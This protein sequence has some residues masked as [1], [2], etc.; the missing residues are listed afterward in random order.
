M[1]FSSSVDSLINSLEKLSKLRESG[2]ITEAEFLEA[3]ASLLEGESRHRENLRDLNLSEGSVGSEDLSVIIPVVV[4][5]MKLAPKIPD[6]EPWILRFGGGRVKGKG[7]SPRGLEF[8]TLAVCPPD[9]VVF[10]RKSAEVWRKPLKGMKAE[11]QAIDA[12]RFTAADGESIRWITGLP[13][14]KQLINAFETCL[15]QLGLD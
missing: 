8:M 15:S 5:D 13:Y 9:L 12:V 4:Y 11:P 2:A 3:K 6:S 7:V 14:R 1:R 10:G